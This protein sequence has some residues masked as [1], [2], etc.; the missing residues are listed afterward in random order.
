TKISQQLGHLIE[1]F[2]NINYY[3]DIKL[4]NPYH[5]R[6]GGGCDLIECFSLKTMVVLLHIL[7]YR[8]LVIITDNWSHFL[9]I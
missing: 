9:Q 1:K 6:F 3:Q 4:Y 8:T 2:A 7:L 5:I